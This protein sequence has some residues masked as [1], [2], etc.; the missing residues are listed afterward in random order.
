LRYTLRTLYQA[1]SRVEFFL[2][3]DQ[4]TEGQVICSSWWF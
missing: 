4:I 2:A 1:R 3:K